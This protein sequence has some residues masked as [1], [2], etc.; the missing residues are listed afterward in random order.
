[1][2]PE[3][4]LPC[5]LRQVILGSILGSIL[6]TGNSPSEAFRLVQHDSGIIAYFMC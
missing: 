4:E 6:G 2:V 5:R 3:Q 1:M